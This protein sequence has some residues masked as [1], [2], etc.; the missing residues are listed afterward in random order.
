MYRFKLARDGIQKLIK[1]L[2]KMHSQ[3][4]VTLPSQRDGGGKRGGGAV[5]IPTTVLSES[6]HILT[7]TDPICWGHAGRPTKI[8]TSSHQGEKQHYLS[9]QSDPLLCQTLL[10]KPSGRT[11]EKKEVRR[12]VRDT[13]RVSSEKLCNFNNSPNTAKSKMLWEQQNTSSADSAL[14][15]KS[16]N[17]ASNL[18][19]LVEVVVT[20]MASCPPPS[21][22]CKGE[23]P[24]HCSAAYT[25]RGT[26]ARVGGSPALGKPPTNPAQPMTAVKSP[27]PIPQSLSSSG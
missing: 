5:S 17:L 18:P 7:K 2:A 25:I 16:T 11:W 12:Q 3:A 1:T 23:K 10:Q 4:S 22:T 13:I 27:G 15:E 14:P 9:D 19:I 24:Q 6:S 26:T 21:T 20:S 8:L